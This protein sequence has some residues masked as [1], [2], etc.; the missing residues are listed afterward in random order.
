MTDS[1]EPEALYDVV[2]GVNLNRPQVYREAIPAKLVDEDAVRVLQRLNRAGFEAYLVGGGVRDLLLGRRPKD[3]DIATDARPPEMRRLFRNCRIIGRRFRLA[4]V[5]FAEGKVIEVAT[6]RRDPPKPEALL[7][8]VEPLESMDGDDVGDAFA[9][10]RV[11]HHEHADLLIRDDNFFGTPREDATRRDF[12]VNGLFYDLQA[13]EVIDYVGGM[14]DLKCRVVRTIGDPNVR[15]REDPVRLLRAI[16]FCARLDF[17]IDADLVD[18]MISLRD[19][20]RRA[21]QARVFEE[22]LRLLRGGAAQRSFYL[23]WETGALAVL[24]PELAA[25]LD[26]AEPE[27]LRTWQ[28]LMVVDARVRAGGKLSD[29]VLFAALLQGPGEEVMDGARDPLGAFEDFM[30]SISARL[31]VPRRIKEQLKALLWSQRLLRAGKVERL[32]QRDFFLD[33]Q[34]LYALELEAQGRPVPRW[35]PRE[36]GEGVRRTRS[37]RRRFSA[38]V[39]R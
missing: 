8:E 4:H 30:Q 6:F 15:L 36:S 29:A 22:M 1:I 38:P 12:T 37:R 11:E 35:N 13:G 7:A 34:Q 16:K 3:F 39:E 18:S 26:D 21:A 32:A 17:G 14:A 27:A 31:A 25:F 9:Q 5:L 20:L 24:L 33:A 19:E 2:D 23:L 10:Q 28:R